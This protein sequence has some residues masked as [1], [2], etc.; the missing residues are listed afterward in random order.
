MRTDEFRQYW[1]EM[2]TIDFALANRRLMMQRIQEVIGEVM[3]GTVFEPMINIAHNYAAFWRTTSARMSSYPRREPPH[4][5]E[6][7]AS[8]PV[9]RVH[10]LT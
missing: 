1:A 10:A 3:P 4:A 5:K 7:W 9:H 8:F 6:P 2:S